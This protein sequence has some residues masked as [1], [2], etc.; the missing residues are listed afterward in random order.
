MQRAEGPR[1]VVGLI[2]L[3]FLVALLMS[4]SGAVIVLDAVTP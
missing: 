4:A 2:A 1:R 3:A